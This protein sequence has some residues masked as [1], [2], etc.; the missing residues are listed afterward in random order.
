VIQFRSWIL[1]FYRTKRRQM[2]RLK[3]IRKQRG[4][5][6]DQLAKLSGVSRPSIARIETRSEYQPR[7]STIESL[8]VTL[9]VIDL[10]LLSEDEF[11]RQLQ[12]ATLDQLLKLNRDLSRAAEKEAF[13]TDRHRH[14]LARI[15]KV[16]DRF[17]TLAGPFGLVE[18]S[19]SRKEREAKAAAR[20]DQE[21][22]EAIA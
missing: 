21:G 6:Q 8:T 18:T 17:N 15:G 1:E 20:E 11:D 19:R 10:E 3:E 16:V 13:G 4:L 7:E 14:L 5:S 2:L 12:S 9:G 22:G